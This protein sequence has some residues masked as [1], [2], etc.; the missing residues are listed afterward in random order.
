MERVHSALSSEQRNPLRLGEVNA[1]P[2]PRQKKGSENKATNS[3]VPSREMLET[4]TSMVGFGVTRQASLMAPSS[5][6]TESKEQQQLVSH[7][8]SPH[9]PCPS[10]AF[11]GEPSEEGAHPATPLSSMRA[12]FLLGVHLAPGSKPL[13]CPLGLGA[14]SAGHN[15]GQRELPQTQSFIPSLPTIS[16]A[17]PKAHLQYPAGAKLSGQ[18]QGLLF[19]CWGS[20]SLQPSGK[21]SLNTAHLEKA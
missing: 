21:R 2:G 20:R 6:D 3:V 9:L 13:A 12:R 16:F 5:D 11:L 8:G 19:S 17:E 10:P 14:G 7:N 18:S 1:T 4:P 15:L